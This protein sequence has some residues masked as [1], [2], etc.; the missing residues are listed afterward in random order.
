MGATEGTHSNSASGA[1][2][3]SVCIQHRD[4]FVRQ[5]RSWSAA[6]AAAAGNV[7]G[8]LKSLSL[9]NQ[10]HVSLLEFRISV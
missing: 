3:V 7:I 2:P 8:A 4:P 1:V 5:D 9:Q 10:N 6:A